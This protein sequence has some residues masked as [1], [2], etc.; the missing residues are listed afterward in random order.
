MADALRA[1]I[2]SV[3]TTVFPRSRLIQDNPRY[4]MIG[5]GLRI[6]ARNFYGF[7]FSNT[8]CFTWLFHIW[9]FPGNEIVSNLPLQMSLYFNA[10]F[11]PFWFAT[12]I[13]MLFAKVKMLFSIFN[14]WYFVLF[15]CFTV[16]RHATR[17]YF[18]VIFSAAC[19]A[20]LCLQ[21]HY[22]RHLRCHGNS[23]DS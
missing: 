20:G 8:L 1:A 17:K 11:S 5:T 12:C 21:V 18:V 4:R 10:Y 23:G 14:M 7:Y 16:D 22:N 2:S 15:L 6:I 9:T 19:E 13:V 3:T